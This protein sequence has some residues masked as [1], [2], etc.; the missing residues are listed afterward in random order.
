M[1]KKYEFTGETC[2][3]Q[4]RT[5]HRIRA[6]IDIAAVGL[7]AGQLGGWIETEANLS[8][9]GT[10]WVYEQAIVCGS[11]VIWGGTIRGGTI[12]GGTIRGGTIKGGTIRGGTIRGGTIYGGV[13]WGGT[14]WG[15]IIEGGT[16]RGGTIYGGTIRGGIIE[17]GTIKGGTI[18]GGTIKTSAD[19]GAHTQV[20]S[21][22][23]VLTWT[24]NDDGEGITLNRG[25]FS[26]TLEEFSEA[27]EKQHGDSKIGREY[28]LLIEFIRLRSS[29]EA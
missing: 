4:G 2:K 20:G 27:V 24:R 13:I 9:S 26:G 11:G 16:I 12:Y 29:K 10:G 25:C 3:Y 19:Y 6:L 8:Q 18:C 21:E 28:R 23:G 17:G 1:I 22:E 7:T 14:I 5:L 15:G